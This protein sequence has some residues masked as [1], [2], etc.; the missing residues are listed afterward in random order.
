[1]KW[2]TEKSLGDLVRPVIR[3]YLLTQ[4]ALADGQGKDGVARHV[5]KEVHAILVDE[6]LEIVGG[7]KS[8]AANLL[9]IH[10]NTLA[11]KKS[12]NPG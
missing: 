4:R 5:L 11:Q 3:E 2:G 12:D 7:N 8:K 6:A 1:M 10:R 9:G